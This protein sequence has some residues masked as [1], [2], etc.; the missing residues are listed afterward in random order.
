M[1][2]LFYTQNTC[3]S[4][5]GGISHITIFLGEYFRQ[6][7]IG[8]WYL[9]SLKTSEP[10]VQNQISF[11][12]QE[13]RQ[14]EKNKL[15][16]IE[17]VRTNNIHIV[18]NQKAI[19]PEHQEILQWTQ[20]TQAKLISVVHQSLFG[21][22]GLSNQE[23]IQKWSGKL[24]LNKPIDVLLHFIFKIKYKKYYQQLIKLS[25]KVILLSNQYRSEIAYFSGIQN[26]SNVVVI[27]NP[28][29]IAV[30]TKALSKEKEI[31]FV[32]RLSS[33]KRVDLL[34]E[35][36][37]SICRK[38]SDWS[39]KLVGDGEKRKNLEV[40]AEKLDLKNISFEGFQAPAS[41]YETASVFCLTSGY[42]AFP[43]VLLE[44][45]SYNVVPM[46]FNSY[47][48]ASEI[49][50]HGINGILISSFHVE[51]YI[52]KLSYLIENEEKRGEMSI[53]AR[54]KMDTFSIEKIFKEWVVLFK[55]LMA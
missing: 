44:A 35:I 54:L 12:D 22:Y 11:P 32:G 8:V 19:S 36:W 48:S 7:G 55:Q 52:E 21:M 2:I 45:M 4:L 1:N 24:H 47:A 26:S 31:L 14:S 51:E 9:S 25:D 20:Q 39:L 30:T 42:E 10:Y 40:L 18:I 5:H 37:D 6:K 13:K 33:Q 38:Y 15:F 17:F 46:T 50:D 27:H 34:L 3:N 49:I 23:N 16:F 43:L 53:Q 41:Y 28:V 29:T